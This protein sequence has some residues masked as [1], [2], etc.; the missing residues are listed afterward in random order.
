MRSGAGKLTV[1]TPEENRIVIQLSLP[2]AIVDTTFSAQPK[3]FQ[4]IGI[5]PGI[6][7]G[8][9]AGDMLERYLKSG[10]PMVL[11]AD[12]LT[13]I[14]KYGFSTASGHIFTPHA[15]EMKRL[16]EGLHL[17]EGTL[18]EQAR[19][20]GRRIPIP[21][22]IE[23][24]PFLDLLSG[25]KRILLSARKRRNGNS[26]QWRCTDRHPDRSLGTGIYRTRN[27]IAGHMAPCDSRRFCSR[28]VGSGI[29]AG[30]RHHTPSA[31]GIY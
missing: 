16:A 1:L 5:G 23:G 8:E 14:A 15:R 17:Q 21:H 27:R 25:R 11:D 19:F 2:E 24:T 12:A 6:G 10:C 3:A 22:H 18:E 30:K 26:R 9:K 28:A 4:S 7:T 29:Y 20:F 31:N 13:L